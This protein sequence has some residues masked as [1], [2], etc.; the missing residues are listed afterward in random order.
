[1]GIGQTGDLTDLDRQTMM[2]LLK[3]GAHHYLETHVY[4]EW[5]RR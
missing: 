1:M 3:L 5:Y 4:A 2:D